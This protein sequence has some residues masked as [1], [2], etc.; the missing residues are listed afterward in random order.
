MLRDMVVDP[1]VFGM[2]GLCA[3]LY[4]A[5]IHLETNVK[6][7]TG[8][9]F[10]RGTVWLAALPALLF[11]GYYTHLFDKFEWIYILR[12]IPN[13]ELLGAGLGLPAGMVHSKFHPESLGE[14]L[15]GPL[16]VGVLIMAPY[17][18]PVLT[19]VNRTQLKDR[20]SGSTCLQSTP[21]SCGPASAASVL[22]LYG[23]QVTERELAL[24]CHTS[25]TGT[26]NW[27][28]AR[29]LRRR[30]FT[31]EFTIRDGNPI[32]LPD[33]PAIAGVRLPGPTGHFVA[34]LGQ[35]PEH[36]TIADPMKGTLQIKKA[37][38]GHYYKFTGHFLMVRPARSSH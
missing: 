23:M 27:Y 10:L 17:S 37:D 33:A 5:G 35:S 13:I 36:V 16:V 30:G 8:R 3:C 32:V 9:V 38:L 12:T 24:E 21:S 26:E 20:W 11:A 25:R 4:W 7:K 2:V 29:A 22:R 34:V 31:A 19:P 6:G 1:A 14:K 15:A 18:K 28:L